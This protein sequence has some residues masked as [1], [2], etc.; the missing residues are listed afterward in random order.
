MR[1]AIRDGLNPWKTPGFKMSALAGIGELFG[2]GTDVLF[3]HWRQRV[4]TDTTDWGLC[5]VC[6]DA[7][8][9]LTITRLT[10]PELPPIWKQEADRLVASGILSR[11]VA[12][13]K[14]AWDHQGWLDFLAG[15]RSAGYTRMPDNEIGLL[16]EQEKAR[17]WSTD[18]SPPQSV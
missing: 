15:V 2:L 8:N 10:P 9:Q 12:E 3:N 1:Q 13:K 17:F 11:F 4:M 5:P 6:T 18:H 14:G 16:L 7:L